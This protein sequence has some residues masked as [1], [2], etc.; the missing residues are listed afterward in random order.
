[1][2]CELKK[3]DL[4]TALSLVRVATD[5]KSTMPLLGCV[6]VRVLENDRVE[7]RATDLDVSACVEIACATLEP[8]DIALPVKVLPKIVSETPGDALSFELEENHILRVKAGKF[9]ARLMGMPGRDMPKIPEPGDMSQAV[10]V[11]A[12]QLL[13]GLRGT[14][15]ASST[16]ETRYHLNGV[17]L[18]CT[19][20]TIVCVATDGHRLVKRVLDSDALG[21]GYRK[22][23]IVSSKGVRALS[24]FLS[25][26]ETAKM[27]ADQFAVHVVAD[28]A[29]V[30]IRPIQSPFPPYEKVIPQVSKTAKFERSA[31]LSALEHERVVSS[32]EMRLDMRRGGMTLSST[33]SQGG[34]EW[35]EE[36]P[37]YYNGKKQGVS[38]NPK[39]LRDALRHLASDVVEM[40]VT[41][42]L[43]PMLLRDKTTTC[44]LMPVRTS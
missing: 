32:D 1:M 7:V 36:V 15:Y 19:G 21:D 40:G 43:E 23:M 28:D 3:S 11:D 30:A 5:P 25:R 27:V 42:E 38:F 24:A 6:H 35:R 4:V 31:L 33:N 8:G 29:R 20:D 44:V 10:N 16:D 17:Y 12:A 34:I 37:C 18:D 39:Y 22:A 14:S 41:D 2:R 9:T 26:R 13:S